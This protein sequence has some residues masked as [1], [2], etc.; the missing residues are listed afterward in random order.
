MR[1][2]G[3]KLILPPL[4]LFMLVV[5]LWHLTVVVFRVPAFLLPDPMAVLQ[6]AIA[7]WPALS[8]AAGLTA[9]GALCGFLSSLLVGA[10]IAFVFAQSDLIQRS[11]Y[12]YA[13]FLQTVPIVAIAPLIIIWFGTGFRSVVIVAFIISLFPVITNG[14]AGLTAIQPNLRELFAIYNANRWQLLLKLRLPNA[15][16]H[17]ITGAKISSGLSVIG[18]I[19]GE[20]FAGY[21]TSFGLGYL[22]I[23]TS[24]QFKTAYLFA[25]IFMSTLLGVLIF[26]AVNLL[27]NWIL[28]RWY[29]DQKC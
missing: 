5:I 25:A 14:V 10:V 17:F 1:S 20:F 2:I 9:L 19:V 21:G 12:P 26:G 7:N 23:V 3:L 4:G 11:F 28:R 22:I 16:P 29:G 18:A 24:S 8:S 6:A 15:V 27:G 13:I